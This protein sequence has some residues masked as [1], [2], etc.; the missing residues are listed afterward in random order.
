MNIWTPYLAHSAV[1]LP[2]PMGMDCDYKTESVEEATALEMQAMHECMKHPT[3]ANLATNGGSKKPEKFPRPSIDLDSTAEA[4]QEF[5]TSWLQYKDEYGLT[6]KAYTRQL[7]ACCSQDL[8]TSL[9]RTTG[10]THFDLTESQ[11][12]N[13]IKNLA[14][15]YQNPAVHVQEF[16]GLNQQ[17]DE[18]V[19]HFLARLRGVATRC[20][21]EM[22]CGQGCDGMV[23]YCDTVIRFKLIAG[24]SCSDIKEDIL[25]TDDYI[26]GGNGANHREEGKWETG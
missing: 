7:Y 4:W 26:P 24:L 13:T 9:S 2:C 16:L 22:K 12:I 1:I 20:N 25:S 23:S 8:A 5:H 6:G 21:F 10:G 18:G 14:V 11:L 19:R 3:S 15:R 17:P